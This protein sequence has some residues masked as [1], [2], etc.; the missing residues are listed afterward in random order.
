MTPT[1]Q[2]YEQIEREALALTW[3]CELFSDF[4]IIGKHFSLETDH[5]PQV[6]LLG[7]K[8]ISDLPP[9]FQRFRMRPLR[10]D[11]D[12]L[13]IPGKELYTPDALS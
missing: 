4:I 1:V 9:R 10:F 7:G 6:S 8:A 5:K 13:Y 2:R 11:Y 3:A 12:I